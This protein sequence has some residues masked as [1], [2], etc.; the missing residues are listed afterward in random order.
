[1]LL[2]CRSDGTYILLI[3]DDGVGFEDQ[4]KSGPPGEHIGLSIMEERARRLGG[5]LRIESDPGEGA[6]VELSYKPKGRQQVVDKR[7]IV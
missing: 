5:T 6:R 2:T 7:W 4:S 3:E 1:V